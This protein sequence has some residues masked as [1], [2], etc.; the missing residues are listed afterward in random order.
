MSKPWDR[1]KELEG[2]H[3]KIAKTEI[4]PGYRRRIHYSDGWIIEVW[5]DSLTELGYGYSA[6]THLV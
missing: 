4:G 3:G 1:I 2:A 6:S 5:R